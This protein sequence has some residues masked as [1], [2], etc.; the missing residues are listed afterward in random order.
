MN[1]KKLLWFVGFVVAAVISCW[2]TSSSLILIMPSLFGTNIV[3]RYI[4]TWLLVLL[5]YVL[6]SL[7]LSWVID[8]LDNDGTLDHPKRM[9]WGGLATLAVTWI[10]VS[11]PTNAH[12]FFYNKNIGETIIQDLSTTRKYSKQLA[13]RTVVDSAYWAFEKELKADWKKF[14]DEVSGGKHGSGVGKYAIAH[15][16]QINA[17]LPSDIHLDPPANTDQAPL[18]ELIGILKHMRETQFDPVLRKLQDAHRV[19]RNVAAKAQVDVNNIDS[20]TNALNQYIYT[21]KVA[22]EADLVKQADGVLKEAYA[23]IKNNAKYVKFDAGDGALYNKESIETRI[24]RFLNPYAV[25]S[26]FFQGKIA[27]TFLLWIVLSIGIDLAGFF[28]FYQWVH[29]ED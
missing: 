8:A 4:M 3:V 18:N 5:F 6:A 28:F 21:E 26:D 15:I 17:K 9:F 1:S 25:M 10:I 23:N 7:A 20:M 16:S 19:S 27:R 24:S 14:E 11:L 22:E 13:D 12:T 2:A 29:C